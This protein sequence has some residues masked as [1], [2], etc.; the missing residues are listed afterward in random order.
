MRGSTPPGRVTAKDIAKAAGVSQATVS[1]A[2]RGSPEI[3]EKRI[4]QIRELANQMNYHPRAAAQLLRS[5]LAGQIGVLV[6]SSDAVQA[7]STG[8]TGPL[9]GSVIDVC[10][11]KST[12]YV[13]EFHSH[14]DDDVWTKQPP[15]QVASG[16]VD[17]S[18]VIGDVGEQVRQMLGRDFPSY[19]W[20]N[21]DEPAPYCVLNDSHRGVLDVLR[22]LH[23]IGHRRM[24]YLC[25]PQRY[26]THR[27]GFGAWRSAV[28]ELGIPNSAKR[29]YVIDA[30]A[31]TFDHM[32]TLAIEWLR[33]ALREDDRPTAIVCHDSVIARAAVHAATELGL[34]IPRDLSV[35][36]WGWHVF[37]QEQYPALSTVEFDFRAMVGAAMDMLNC[38][39]NGEQI[40][41][42]RVVVPPRYVEGATVAPPPSA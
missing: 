16:L 24:A 19:P 15:Y 3:G 35:T 42:P 38:R 34:V 23:G 4:L 32:A 25:G 21:I 9:V 36:S 22:R 8:F 11:S 37:A 7:F 12:R 33:K 40:E 26:L 1:M 18:I 28:R 10:V 30:S 41:E 6:G 5:K 2:L 39:I 29:Q 27:Q 20:V 13:I 14:A 31:G 17:G